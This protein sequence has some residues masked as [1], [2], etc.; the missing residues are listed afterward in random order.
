MGRPALHVTQDLLDA[1]AAIAAERGPAAVSMAAVAQASGA[2]SG[3]LYHRFGG[4]AGLLG[5]L[6]LRAVERFQEGFLLALD[7]D[8]PVE[9]CVGAAIH[10]VRWSRRHR[11]EAA[12]LLRGAGE[13]GREEWPAEVLTRARE[14]NAAMEERLRAVAA[15]MG[16]DAPERVVLATVDLPYAVVRRHLVAGR[17]PARAEALVEGSVRAI[18]AACAPTSGGSPGSR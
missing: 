7:G 17:I 14:A 5:E 15:R 18:L 11:S 1:A 3:S 16:D 13:F 12:M 2:P 8:E 10:V 6:W 4:R 9:A